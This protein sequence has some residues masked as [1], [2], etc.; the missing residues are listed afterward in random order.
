MPKRRTQNT[1]VMNK[2]T[3]EDNKEL[4]NATIYTE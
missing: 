1:S 4:E 3:S 2:V